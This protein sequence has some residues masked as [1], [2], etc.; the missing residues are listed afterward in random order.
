[1][2]QLFLVYS[3]GDLLITARVI[4]NEGETPFTDLDRD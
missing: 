2:L 3:W 1:M 4:H